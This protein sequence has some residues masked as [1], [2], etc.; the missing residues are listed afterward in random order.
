MFVCVFLPLYDMVM[1]GYALSNA[2]L[3]AIGMGMGL[4]S[5]ITAT[6]MAPG[7]AFVGVLNSLATVLI[8]ELPE[9]SPGYLALQTLMNAFNP[10]LQLQS[11]TP[12]PVM[13]MPTVSPTNVIA[14]PQMPAPS[15]SLSAPKAPTPST[16]NFTVGNTCPPPTPT[17]AFKA[18]YKG[19]LSNQYNP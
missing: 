12:R 14:T 15:P 7:T 19:R 1:Y 16:P 17:A 9:G 18:Y 2:W 13:K 6:P 4:E 10:G 3:C 5:I 8:P 11:C